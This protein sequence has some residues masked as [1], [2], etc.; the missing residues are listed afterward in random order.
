MVERGVWSGDLVRVPVVGNQPAA[1]FRGDVAYVRNLTEK[2]EI[3]V[4]RLFKHPLAEPA[5][6]RDVNFEQIG[7]EPGVIKARP[8]PVIA[9]KPLAAGCGGHIAVVVLPLRHGIERQDNER[10]RFL[11]AR[12]PA[13]VAPDAVACGAA[14]IIILTRWDIIGGRFA[15]IAVEA[16]VRIA[17]FHICDPRLRAV[18]HTPVQ[19]KRCGQ[20]EC[21]RYAV[22][23][24]A[25]A[26][27]CDADAAAAQLRGT[28]HAVS[29]REM[30][31]GAV[32]VHGERTR[33]RKKICLPG[34]QLYNNDR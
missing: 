22:R 10:G 23:R 19:P 20:D 16:P 14:V 2:G 4:H 32:F 33:Q 5:G 9:L 18:I 11:A 31:P 34:S 25:I 6:G 28:Q 26:V 7:I 15:E 17:V 3:A 1:V 8:D 24:K 21:I 12:H 13:K 29:I 30:L 27:H